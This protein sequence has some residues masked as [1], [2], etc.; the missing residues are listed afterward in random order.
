MKFLSYISCIKFRLYANE[1]IFLLYYK[2]MLKI[3]FSSLIISFSSLTYFVILNKV[4]QLLIVTYKC[5]FEIVA[6][7]FSH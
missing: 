6:L 3:S 5:T 1:Y 7:L 4:I 2:E